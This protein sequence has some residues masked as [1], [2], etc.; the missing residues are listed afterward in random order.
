MADFGPG[1]GAP[2]LYR[3][4]P[5]R[6]LA[7]YA[8]PDDPE[9]SCGATLARWAADGSHVHVL[10]C[11]RGEKGSLDPATDP[12]E[13]ARRRVAEMEAS[14]LV[15][16]LSGRKQLGF[17]DGEL[18]DSHELRRLLVTA[19]RDVRPQVVLCNDPTAV[20]FGDT[21]Y[22]HADH[23]LT[24]WA[25]LDSVSPAAGNPHYF[26]EAGPAHQVES[27]FMSATLEPN[28][29]VDVGQAIDTKIEAVLCHRSQLG[30]GGEFYRDALRQ[31]AEDGGRLAGVRY[32][33]GFRRLSL[34]G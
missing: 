10:V 8:H 1:G 20:F 5:A 34:A 13:L 21:Y 24:G 29:W 16:G 23:R 33:E 2:A 30:E 31:R 3:E 9:I 27:V 15:L 19:I 28:V 11:A 25:V 32:A 26:P 7:I 6:A 12:D 14:G 18:P 17:R 4:T 22:N